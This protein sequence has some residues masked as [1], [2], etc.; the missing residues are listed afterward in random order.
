[1]AV[2]TQFSYTSLKKFLMASS[3][4][5]LVGFAPMDVDARDEVAAVTADAVL[6]PAPSIPLAAIRGPPAPPMLL[7]PDAY[8]L[9]AAVGWCSSRNLALEPVTK[10]ET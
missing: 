6:L 1:M 10:Q 7:A 9:D 2:F 3:V 4:A 5:A 8:A